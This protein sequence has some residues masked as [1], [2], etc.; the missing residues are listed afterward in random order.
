[1]FSKLARKYKT[2]NPLDS[3]PKSDQTASTSSFGAAP[4][5]GTDLS[6]SMGFGNTS[7]LS[8]KPPGSSNAASLFG[9]SNSQPSKNDG[10]GGAFNS[11]FGGSTQA[12]PFGQSTSTATNSTPFGQPVAA[13]SSTPFGQSLTVAKPMTTTPFGQISAPAPSSTPFAITNANTNV[14][15]VKFGGKTAREI[16]VAFYQQRN[17]AQLAKVDQV[18][19]KYAGKEEQLL[20]NLA[21]KYNMDPAMFGLT[22]TALAPSTSGFGPPTPAF[23]QTT[24]FGSQSSAAFGQSSMLGHTSQSNA[25]F[26]QSPGAAAPGGFGAF[27]QSGNQSTGFGSISNGNGFGSPA[28]FSSPVSSTP[29]GA[30]RR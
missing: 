30:A 12:A 10:F 6:T 19:Q 28:T 15:G 11:P 13:T 8:T 18:L 26:G 5:P 22:A 17:P 29:F 16:L 3:D 14:G 25:T 4:L 2:Q 24:G 7:T 20:R 23:G 27:A 1:M 9:Q 21:K